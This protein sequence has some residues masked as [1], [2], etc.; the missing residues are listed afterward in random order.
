MKDT[1]RDILFAITAGIAVALASLYAFPVRADAPELQVHATKMEVKYNLPPGMLR[2]ICEQE[3]RWRNLAGQ[4]GEIG[5]CQI[6][7]G[8]VAMI[9]P[10]CNGNATRSFFMVGS[11]G[12]N[13]ARIQAVLARERLYTAAIDGV[14]GPQTYVAVLKFQSQGKIAVDGVVGP[15]TWEKMFGAIDPFPGQSITSSL[16]DPRANIEW[17]ARYLAWLRD[18]VANDPAIMIAAYN[19]GPANSVVVYLRQVKGRM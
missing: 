9:C 8:T 4:H 17:A 19:G 16:W 12:D 7:P 6:K 2:A 1:I 15:Q 3:S 14:F 18:N 13:V 5:V 10:G 11:R